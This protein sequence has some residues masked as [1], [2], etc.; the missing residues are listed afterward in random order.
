MVPGPQGENLYAL[1]STDRA[2]RVL[3]EKMGEGAVTFSQSGILLSANQTFADLVGQDSARLAG[4]D[5]THFVHVAGRK[6]WPVCSPTR[7][8]RLLTTS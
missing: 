4:Q 1:A 7:Q 2:Y 3:V 5:L 6:L 8:V